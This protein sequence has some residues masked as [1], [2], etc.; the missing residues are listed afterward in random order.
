MF[1]EA[2]VKRHRDGAVW[3]WSTS[4]DANSCR[5][6]LKTDNILLERIRIEEWRSG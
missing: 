2:N 6:N 1:L 3:R 5:P 4:W